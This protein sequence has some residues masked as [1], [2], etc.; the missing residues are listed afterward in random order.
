MGA[1]FYRTM[2]LPELVAKNKSHYVDI[3]VNL[4]LNQTFFDDMTVC[5]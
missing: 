5:H 3:A 2:N 1:S 4:S